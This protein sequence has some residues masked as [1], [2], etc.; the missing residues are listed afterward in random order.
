MPTVT[1]MHVVTAIQL[2]ILYLSWLPNMRHVWSKDPKAIFSFQNIQSVCAAGCMSL[3]SL[4]LAFVA[5]C[6]QWEQ[7]V[8][9]DLRYRRKLLQGKK[10]CNQ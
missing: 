5:R 10:R 7:L 4:F 1:E 6:L 8:I 9:V 3:K 2:K